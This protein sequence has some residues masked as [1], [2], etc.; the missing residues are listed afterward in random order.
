MFNYSLFGMFCK[1]RASRTANKT[2]S[3]RILLVQA[4]RLVLLYRSVSL[5]TKTYP[6]FQPKTLTT[7]YPSKACLQP[8]LWISLFV[9]FN[10][11]FYLCAGI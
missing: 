9:K 7:N 11:S 1:K 3:E 6:H 2:L 10:Y 4:S 8:I 5:R